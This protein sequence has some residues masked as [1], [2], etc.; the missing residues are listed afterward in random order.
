MSDPRHRSFE[1][2][3][4]SLI[5]GIQQQSD[6]LQVERSL[7][8]ICKRYWF[9]I[10]AF[11]RRGGVSSEDAEDLTQSFFEH[12]LT[13]DLLAQAKAERG[14]LR[15]FLLACLKHFMGNQRRRDRA[16]RRGGGAVFASF[17]GLGAEEFLRVE[18]EGGE[19]EDLDA[20]F[21]REWAH[22]VLEQ[23]LEI[24]RSE[25]SQGA[26]RVRLEAL[27]PALSGNPDRERLMRETGL[28]EG[29]LNVAIHRL[30]R[31][32]GQILRRVVADS[33][34]DPAEL[35][36]ELAHLFACLRRVI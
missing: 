21:D 7:S 22:R 35:D 18:S 2:T 15:S 1:T 24:L 26:E 8:E 10:Y 20:L 23:V 27:L 29:S 4:W 30:R 5:K 6:P 17:E 34:A 13:G 12:L 31:R 33:V 32:Y 19:G 14:R 16:Q 3:R 25:F 36:A 9:P 28:N 11:V